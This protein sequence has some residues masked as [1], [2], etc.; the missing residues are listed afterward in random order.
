MGIL[1]SKTEIKGVTIRTHKTEKKHVPLALVYHVCTGQPT[2]KQKSIGGKGG[3]KSTM[4]NFFGGY[5]SPFLF[6]IVV[7]NM[8]YC[9]TGN[10]FWL[11]LL[12]P[13]VHWGR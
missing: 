8:S 10:K 2:K 1:Y 9:H 12:A 13:S 5:G 7:N 4:Y 11:L 3:F 6:E